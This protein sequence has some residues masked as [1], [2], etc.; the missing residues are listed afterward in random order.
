MFTRD[1]V[2]ILDHEMRENQCFRNQIAEIAEKSPPERPAANA[3]A[4]AESAIGDLAEWILHSV[5]F[6]RQ[7]KELSRQKARAAGELAPG[8]IMSKLE[9]EEL[10]EANYMS[11]FVL[12]IVSFMKAKELLQEEHG[13]LQQ[14]REHCKELFVNDIKRFQKSTAAS[15]ICFWQ[16]T[17]RRGLRLNA[18]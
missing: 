18:K 11:S 10:T 2:K 9:A 14:R 5:P 17:D 8:S 16:P 15:D 4:T 1:D 13:S 12:D 7:T 3:T 6:L